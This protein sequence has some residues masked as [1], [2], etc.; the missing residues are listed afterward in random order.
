MYA[1]RSYYAP[2]DR[3]AV[4]TFTLPFDRVVIRD[5]LMREH[6]RGGQSFYVCPRISDITKLEQT[7]KELVPELKMVVAHGQMNAED[8]IT[9]YNVCYTKLLRV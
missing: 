6:Y 5:A 3:L 8:R 9:S 4:K 7:L 2:I 1:I